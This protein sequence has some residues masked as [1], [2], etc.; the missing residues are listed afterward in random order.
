MLC[1]AEN[2]V[3]EVGA[4]SGAS[5][6]GPHIKVAEIAQLPAALVLGLGMR[7][8]SVR[9]TIPA[10]WSGVCATQTVRWG[11]SIHDLAAAVKLGSPRHGPM[12]SSDSRAHDHLSSATADA[13]GLSVIRIDKFIDPRRQSCPALYRAGHDAKPFDPAVTG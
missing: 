13:A 10:A 6:L 7:V 1:S 3:D 9:H 11:S 8:Y 4:D 12:A 5:V 2:T